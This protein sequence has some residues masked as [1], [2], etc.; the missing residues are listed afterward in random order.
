MKKLLLLLFITLAATVSR[1]QNKIEWNGKYRLQFS[2]FTSPG[3]QIGDTKIVSLST[4]PSI[5][6]SFRMSTA[7]FLFTR[8]RN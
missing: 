6:F 7:V 8:K 2:D 5:D 1:A 3:S 4:A